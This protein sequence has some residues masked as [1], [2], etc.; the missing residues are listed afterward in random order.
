MK[1]D[2]STI[3][4]LERYLK[5]YFVTPHLAED[6]KEVVVKWLESLPDED[7]LYFLDKGWP[8]VMTK[9]ENLKQ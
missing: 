8:T 7:C 6:S 2:E 5:R 1:L 3:E 9:L 4:H